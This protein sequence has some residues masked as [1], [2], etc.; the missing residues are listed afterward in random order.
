VSSTH[1]RDAR[2]TIAPHWFMVPMHS[3]KRDVACLEPQPTAATTSQPR[4]ESRP[5]G[6]PSIA[7][8]DPESQSEQDWI[9]NRWSR[10]DVG[11]FLASSLDVPNGTVTKAISIR[12]GDRDEASVCFDTDNLNL[13]AGWTGGFLRFDAARF[14]LLNPPRIAGDVQFAAPEGPGWI[15]GTGRFSGFHIHDKRVVLEYK[16]GD[17]TVRESP[18]FET[19]GLVSL[20]RRDIEVSPLKT[21]LRLKVIKIGGGGTKRQ[22]HDR[23]ISGETYDEAGLGD[24]RLE[25]GRFGSGNLEISQTNNSLDLVLLGSDSVQRV[26]ITVLNFPADSRPT[27]RDRLCEPQPLDQLTRP[28]TARWLPA[29]E[30]T[31]Q[32][33][34][35]TGPL[36]IDTVTVPYENPWNA[37]MFLSGVD[38]TSDGAAYVC[39]VHG[40]V[41]KVTGID[42]SLGKL[43]WKRFATGLYQP[44]GLKVVNVQVCVLGRD[45]IT[46]LHDAN[47]DGEADYYE[48][49]CNL[50]QTIPEPHHYVAS[51]DADE[52]G[53][54][55]YVD[56]LG[57]HRVSPDGRTMETLATGFR[58]PN[59][60]GVSP[61]GGI[62]T[63][64]PQQGEW[65]PSSL[66]VET[67]RGGYYGYGGPKATPERPLG[68]DPVLCWIPHSVDNFGGSEIWVP[69]DT[70]SVPRSPPALAN[71]HPA[72]DWG[73]LAGHLL[74]FSWGRCS[75]ML[76]LRDVVDGVPQG[77]TVALPGRVLSGAM[78]GAF[79]PHDGELYVVGSTGWQTSALKDGCFQRVHWTG[80]PL[81]V[82]I[83]WHVRSNGLTLTFAQPL[84][85]ETAE[86]V[87]SY[88]LEQW[89]YRYAAQYGSKDWSIS[90]PD[91]EG[92]D[93][94]TVSSAKLLPDDRTVFLETP[95]LKP[96]MQLQ[97]QYNL[98]AKAGASIRGKLY[99]TI[100]RVSKA[101]EGSASSVPPN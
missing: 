67:R 45:Q 33:A 38:F 41:W 4:A 6:T 70:T 85:K 40:D 19:K 39:S 44:L 55:Y 66:I 10:A 84:D 37:L 7:G 91:K 76:V 16:I 86:D 2:A 69:R 77:A 36:A 58:N 18:W 94:L 46:R 99:A 59:G 8:H 73:P 61:D 95:G 54:F 35:K 97:V 60:M 64:A 27:E 80:K 42:A 12:V 96:V 28:G 11:Q 1:G 71:L 26:V 47:G 49:F 100:N 88:G 31:G 82:P 56:P 25:V 87:G 43:T 65:T 62:V 29:V 14:G 81:D 23:P 53:N 74:H 22:W 57:A 15:G 98:D 92:H 51:L 101:V 68:Y 90:D 20:F 17:T 93:P 63:V 34:P 79:N 5:A 13:R 89:N 48:S 32:I 30:T 9:D 78:R 50:I 24:R 83:D 52:R 21:A 72:A 75:L 3:K